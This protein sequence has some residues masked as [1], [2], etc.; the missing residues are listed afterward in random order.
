MSLNRSRLEI[1]FRSISFFKS[2]FDIFL[3][4]QEKNG[5]TFKDLKTDGGDTLRLVV[6]WYMGYLACNNEGSPNKVIAGG[7]NDASAE[8][9]QINNTLTTINYQY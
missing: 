1:V 2:Y 7:V 4:V 6:S 8:E 3:Q 5:E 9:E